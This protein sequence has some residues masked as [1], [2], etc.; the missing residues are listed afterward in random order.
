M[1]A[2]GIKL[3]DGSFYPILEYGKPQKKNLALTTVKDNQTTVHVDLYRSSSSSMA[4]AQYVDTLEIKDLHPHSNG[5]PNLSLDIELDADNK[6]SAKIHDPETDRQVSLMSRPITERSGPVNFA[7]DAPSEEDKKTFEDIFD[8]KKNEPEPSFEDILDSISSDAEAEQKPFAITED[9]VAKLDKDVTTTEVTSLGPAPAEDDFAFETLPKEGKASRSSAKSRHQEGSDEGDVAELPD[10]DESLFADDSEQPKAPE[11]AEPVVAEEKDEPVTTLNDAADTDFDFSTAGDKDVSASLDLPEFNEP[12]ASSSINTETGFEFVDEPLEDTHD[13]LVMPPEHDEAVAMADTETIGNTAEETFDDVIPHD[14][15]LDEE[16][17][18]RKPVSDEGLDLPDFTLD[19]VDTANVDLNKDIDLPPLPSFGDSID[20]AV[21]QSTGST[22]TDFDLPDY[23][24]F[25]MEETEE[26]N[27]TSKALE[28]PNTQ[29]M[30]GPAASSDDFEL[31]AL[32]DFTE[33]EKSFLEDQGDPSSDNS[34]FDW[35]DF[36]SE[37]YADKKDDFELPDFGDISAATNSTLASDTDFEVPDFA[38]DE[39]ES[40]FDKFFGDDAAQQPSSVTP[41][42]MFNDLFDKET[43]EGK[44]STAFEEE[45]REEKK[46]TRIPVIICVACAIICVLC[47]LFLF[48]IPTKFNLIN[49]AQQPQIAE[50]THQEQ[51]DKGKAAEIAGTD[52]KGDKSDNVMPPADT[53]LPPQQ[54]STQEQAVV[55]FTPSGSTSAPAQ[56][57]TTAPRQAEPVPAKE[58]KIVIA[59]VPSQVVPDQPVK[60]TKKVPDIKYT[61]VWGDTLW[62]ISNAYYKNPWRYKYLA[63]YNKLSN[64]NYIK[65]GSVILIPAE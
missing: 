14:D 42:N 50:K 21:E 23:P 59:T 44:S 56:T 46:K 17:A 18:D 11:A 37:D 41:Q 62:D 30:S 27:K 20:E 5:E 10:F 16:L 29:E 28:M 45:K 38:D 60:S 58:N 65:A 13:K 9:D 52:T 4:D 43:I 48:I 35:P 26:T 31:P 15:L 12:D 3:A 22:S 6:L 49:R 54:S 53:S 34:N 1:E 2:I 39:S 57:Q 8:G 61:V 63:Q 32:P 24:D 25:S 19:D 55:T 64:P 36:N 47:L 7:I 40:D 33:T 51:K